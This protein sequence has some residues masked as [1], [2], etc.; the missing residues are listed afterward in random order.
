MREGRENTRWKGV[1]FKPGDEGRVVALVQEDIGSRKI[2]AIFNEASWKWKYANNY[3]GF[4]PNWICLAESELYNGIVGHY[5]VIPVYLEVNRHELFCA[6]SVNTL[7][8]K[9]CRGQGI[10][11]GL[12]KQCYEQLE[13]CG[14]SVVYGYPNDSSYPGFIT[15]LGW[16][17]VFRVKDM[18]YFLNL[19]KISALKFKNRVLRALGEYFLLAKSGY[20]TRDNKEASGS[21]D[22][23][24]NCTFTTEHAQIATLLRNRY[25][26]FVSRSLEYLAW[27]YCKDPTDREVT[28]RSFYD[29]ST[30]NGFYVL[31]IK[32]DPIRTD[33]AVAHIMEFLGAPEDQA[34]ANYMLF[35]LLSVCKLKEVDLIHAYTHRTQ[36]DY[37]VLKSF[38]FTKSNEIHYIVK[39]INKT[40]H[41]RTIF[42]ERNWYISLGDSDHA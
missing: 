35:D 27:R 23:K 30:L 8:R 37:G 4:Y 40:V 3:G 24:E 16:S 33:L 1:P 25:S 10:F 32:R 29:R 2:G 34:L 17:N 13:R 5:T 15:K 9:E 39:V 11:V 31:K 19:N 42:D 22:I 36:H 21:Y 7:T 18:V 41:E 12:A 6:Q 38:G 14:I 28:I 26:C 20:H